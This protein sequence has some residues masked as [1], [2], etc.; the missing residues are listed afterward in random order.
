M[1]LSWIKEFNIVVIQNSPL[2]IR[3]NFN[4]LIF[5]TLR[6]DSQYAERTLNKVTKYFNETYAGLKTLI[7]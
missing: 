3:N 5:D 4:F 2:I 7:A 6:V 1:T